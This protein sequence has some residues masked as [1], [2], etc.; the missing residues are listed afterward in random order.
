MTLRRKIFH[1]IYA[2]FIPSL[3]RSISKLCKTFRRPFARRAKNTGAWQ[4]AFEVL[5]CLSIMS[6]CGILYLS[7]P[8]R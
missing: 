1:L 4:L 5:A 8:V 7:Q 6:N 2:I 3:S